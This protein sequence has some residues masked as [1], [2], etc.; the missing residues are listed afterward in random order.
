MSDPSVACVCLYADR[1]Q[2][3]ERMLESFRSQTYKNKWLSIYDNGDDPFQNHSAPQRRD[4]R[5]R[6]FREPRHGRT[7]GELRNAANTMQIRRNGNYGGWKCPD[8]I[9]HWDC[10][11]WSHPNRLAEQ[12]GLLQ[13]SGTDAVGYREM[14]FWDT[15]AGQFHGAWLYINPDP[16]Y[17]LGT[18]LCYRRSTWERK[19]FAERSTTAE[20]LE[21]CCG[22]RTLG[23]L[24]VPPIPDCCSCDPLPRMIAAVHYWNTRTIIV[25]ESPSWNRAPEWNEFCRA[26]ME[27]LP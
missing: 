27:M 8:I 20:D 4:W 10:D 7:I 3:I 1:P 22:L 12:V 18:S 6:C 13:A 16:A 21:F 14:L 26:H 19:P 2:F 17:V 5:E 9:A 23:V 15:R 25:R 11:D 24:S